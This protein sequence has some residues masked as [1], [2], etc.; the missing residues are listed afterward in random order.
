M[1]DLEVWKIV[2]LDFPCTGLLVSSHGNLKRGDFRDK[3]N[4][5]NGAGYKFAPIAV[6]GQRKQRSFYVHR[7]VAEKFIGKPE[8]DDMQVNHIDGDKS[9]N[10]VNN[11]EWVSPK[12]NIKHM[13]DKGLNKGRAEHGTTVTLSDSV[14]A[15]AYY[16]VKVGSYGVREAADKFGMPRTTLSSI[17]NKRSRCKVTDEVDKLMEKGFFQENLRSISDKYLIKYLN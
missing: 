10:H 17:V 1:E 2:E 16:C 7:L 3:K 4:G 9:N 14:I 8:C 5:D 12:D 11:L 13:H 15:E 6:V